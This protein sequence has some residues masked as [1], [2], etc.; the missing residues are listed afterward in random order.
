MAPSNPDPRSLNA[1]PSGSAV[2]AHD[3]FNLLTVLYGHQDDL[4]D[5]PPDLPQRTALVASAKGIVSRLEEIG[6]LLMSLSHTEKQ[7]GQ[8]G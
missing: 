8:S 2:V 4:E 3:V 6:R 5:L 7:A 1:Q